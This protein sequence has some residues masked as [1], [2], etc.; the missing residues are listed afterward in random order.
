MARQRTTATTPDELLK[1]ADELPACMHYGTLRDPAR[2]PR[3]RVRY[4]R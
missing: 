4:A 3:L 2:L 1:L